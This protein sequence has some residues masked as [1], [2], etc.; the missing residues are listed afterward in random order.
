LRGAVGRKVRGGAAAR[1]ERVGTRPR[2]DVA[3]ELEENDRFDLPPSDLRLGIGVLDWWEVPRWH[4]MIDECS[5]W[6]DPRVFRGKATT[7]SDGTRPRIPSE[8]GHRFRLIMAPGYR[9]S[10]IRSRGSA[11]RSLYSGSRGMSWE[12]EDWVDEEATGHRGADD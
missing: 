7:D 12:E 11:P 1:V 9:V 2:A 5:V 8:R 10:W 3:T 4:E 6:S